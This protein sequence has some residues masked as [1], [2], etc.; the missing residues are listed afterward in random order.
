M[1][2]IGISAAIIIF[3][4][5]P[6]A[7]I[8]A[9]SSAPAT[10]KAAFVEVRGKV[11]VRTGKTVKTAR[12]GTSIKVADT[13]ELLTKDSFAAI[14]TGEG[15]R[16]RLKGI[17]RVRFTDLLQDPKGTVVTRL[18]LL[19]GRV[20]AQVKKLRTSASAFEIKAGG[21][22][23]GVRGTTLGGQYDADVKRGAFYNYGGRVF[24]SDGN[25]ELMIDKGRGISFTDGLLGDFTDIPGDMLNVENPDEGETGKERQGAS[26]D[27]GDDSGSDGSGDSVGGGLGGGLS[28]LA[29][30]AFDTDASMGGVQD[31]LINAIDI[32]FESP[33]SSNPFGGGKFE[34]IE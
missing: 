1:K 21:V 32:L 8:C 4:L 24:V 33:E 5:S 15:T 25:R 31:D 29:D 19:T 14:L 16:I 13:V 20:W 27:D 10:L 26:G 30:A 18:R 17:T 22:V 2:H 3:L 28:D 12:I 34:V 11:T 7:S 23:C 6:A 9:P